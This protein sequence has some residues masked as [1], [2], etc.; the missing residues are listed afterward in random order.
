MKRAES[1][2]Q[3]DLSDFA[4]EPGNLFL[5]RTF[6]LIENTTSYELK[7]TARPTQSD[8]SDFAFEPGNLFL[9]GHLG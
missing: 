4:F 5:G 3:S 6:G 2:S 7:R 9:G 1:L 8:L